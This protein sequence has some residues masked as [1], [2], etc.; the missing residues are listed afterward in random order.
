MEGGFH[1]H[2]CMKQTCVKKWLSVK[3]NITR[4]H[5]TVVKFS[6]THSHYIYAYRY[7]CKSDR[8]VFHSPGHPDLSDVGSRVLKL[9]QKLCSKEVGKGKLA[10]ISVV[11]SHAAPSQDL[12][13]ILRCWIT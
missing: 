2:C 1:Y 8:E 13:P 7:V 11:M 3:N 5:N 9:A 10:S 6:D 12:S 4:K